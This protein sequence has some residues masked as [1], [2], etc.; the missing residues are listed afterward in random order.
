MILLGWVFVFETNSCCVAS[1]RQQA[2]CIYLLRPGIL[3]MHHCALLGTL[4][5][6]FFAC[7]PSPTAACTFPNSPNLPQDKQ[8]SGVLL[9][10]FGDGDYNFTFYRH[11]MVWEWVQNTLK[12]GVPGS[13]SQLI[14]DCDPKGLAIPHLVLDS[15]M[16]H[17]GTF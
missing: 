16:A 6:M 8:N 12:S 11:H 7:P 14:Y 9:L 10:L 1:N 5:F 2:S 17:L 4:L 15:S 3:G 13:T